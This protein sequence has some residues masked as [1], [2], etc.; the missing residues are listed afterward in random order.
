MFDSIL[1]IIGIGLGIIGIGGSY[2]AGKDQQKA[3]DRQAA[4]QNKVRELEFQKQAVRERREKFKLIREARI[5]RA[6]A[7]AAASFQGAQG[8][9]RGGFGSII[10][11]QS[12]G[13]QFI[14][15]A[16]S[17]TGQQNIFYNNAAMFA[18]RARDAGTRQ[19]IFD[20]ATKMGSSI[21]SNRAQY[22]DFLKGF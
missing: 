3:L 11:Q 12:S 14:N 4:E 16:V 20:G 1:G 6:A 9:V 8:S 17:L 2:F 21:F 7:I 22:T 5:K 15:Q 13:L 18:S 19:A 10:S